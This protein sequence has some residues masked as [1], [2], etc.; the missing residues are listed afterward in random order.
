MKI[1][2]LVARLLLGLMFLVFG[3]NGFLNF[4]PMGPMPTGPAGQFMTALMISHYMSVVYAVEVTG[5]IL[6]L[7]N[8]YQALALTILAP[9]IVNIV[10]FHSFMAPSGLPMAAIVV[11]LWTLTAYRVRS[12]FAGLLQRR[13]QTDEAI[14][15][16]RMTK[17]A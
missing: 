4:M 6:L 12:V 5:G 13:V 1:V 2:S 10:L 14:T 9:V 16:L 11:V 17:A 3:L 8:Q 7:A 15:N